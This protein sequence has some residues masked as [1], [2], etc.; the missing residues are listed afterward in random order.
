MKGKNVTAHESDS[1]QVGG[2]MNLQQNCIQKIIKLEWAMFQKVRSLAPATCQSNPNA[3]TRIRGAIFRQWPFDVLAAYLEYLEAAQREGRNL[4]TEKY[5]RMDN[6]IGAITDHPR[7]NDIVDIETQWQQQIR[8]RY[9]ALYRRV[10]RDTN[11]EDNGSNFSVYLRCELETYGEKAIGH[12]YEWV[13][14]GHKK[15]ENHAIAMLQELVQAEGFLSIEQ[16]ENYFRKDPLAWIQIKMRAADFSISEHVIRFI[17]A[18]LITLNEI[19][20]AIANGKIT[21]I[22]YN[23]KKLESWLVTGNANGKALSVLCAQVNEDHLAVL[24]TF[25]VIPPQWEEL[26]CSTMI[27]EAVMSQ[28]IKQC[29]FCGGEVTPIVMGNFDYRLEGNLYVVK[30]VPGGLCRECGEKYVSADTAKIL[31]EL[32]LS[33]DGQETESINVLS[34]PSDS[35][36]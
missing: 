19:E 27:Q 31:N 20:T 2:I 28:E 29:Y 6:K 8:D 12:Y 5:A 9:P 21:K 32:V 33:G 26:A 36:K 15:G 25:L 30:N 22:H 7:L 3:F 1:I 14:R 23:H 35:F 11:L 34:Y 13:K 17:T 24:L 4:L 16:A 18:R 10:C